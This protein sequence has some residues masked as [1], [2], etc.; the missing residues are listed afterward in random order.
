MFGRNFFSHLC[1]PVDWIDGLRDD[2]AKLLAQHRSKSHEEKV[3]AI[4]R[5]YN[6]SYPFAL[7]EPYFRPEAMARGNVENFLA[8]IQDHLARLAG[9]KATSLG[10]SMSDSRP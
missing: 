8:A 3:E 9:M 10:V 1:H 6:V 7:F 2:I 4:A 5:L